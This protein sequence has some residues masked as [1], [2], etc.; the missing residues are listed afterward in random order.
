MGGNEQSSTARADLL[1]WSAFARTAP[2]LARIGERLFYQ[3]DDI[4]MAYLATV[5]PDGGPRVH[6]VC[7]VITQSELALFIVNL[8]PKY[9]DLKRN[10]MYALH[11]RQ[12]SATDASTNEEFHLRGSAQEISDPKVKGELVESLSGRQ[13]T[14]EFEALFICTVT[15]ALHTRWR[16]WGTEE[17]WPEFSKWVAE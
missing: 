1:N 12:G 5:A 16:N 7:P 14:Q 11:A 6:P 3:E 9:R 8:S 4:A 17:A 10:G 2:D 13:G 15:S